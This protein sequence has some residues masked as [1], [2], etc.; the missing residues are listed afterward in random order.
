MNTTVPIQ[1]S[2]KFFIKIFPVFFALVNPASTIANPAC[3]QNTSAAPIKNH[4]PNVCSLTKLTIASS[5]IIIPPLFLFFNRFFYK[6][7]DTFPVIHSFV[8]RKKHRIFI[9]FCS[10]FIH[11]TFKNLSPCEHGNF[12]SSPYN[13][14]I[15][16]DNSQ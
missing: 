8:A 14:I 1:K 13:K 4:I 7:N 15:V 16:N 11:D 3:I 9:F 6:K 5:V 2:I 12:I 10:Q